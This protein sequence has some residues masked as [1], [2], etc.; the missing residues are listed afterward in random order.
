MQRDPFKVFRQLH[1]TEFFTIN[2]LY[3]TNN[4]LESCLGLKEKS[5]ARVTSKI[6]HGGPKSRIKVLVERMPEHA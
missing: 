3:I 4:P 2:Q 6:P 1:L 5:F